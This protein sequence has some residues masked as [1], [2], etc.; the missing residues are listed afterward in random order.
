MDLC[1]IFYIFHSND[2]DE[3]CKK[4]VVIALTP[5][6]D[7]KKTQMG[8]TAVASAVVLIAN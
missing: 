6:I 7:C 3:T 2:I 1:S 5:E 4:V 8:L